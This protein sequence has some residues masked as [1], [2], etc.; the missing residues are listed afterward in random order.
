MGP[1]TFVRLVIFCAGVERP[2]FCLPV[3][4]I[5]GLV[6]A[7]VWGNGRPPAAY[8]Q[9]NLHYHICVCDTGAS[10]HA[11]LGS[12]CGQR[13]ALTL[14]ET[15]AHTMGTRWCGQMSAFHLKSLRC[16]CATATPG[17]VLPTNRRAVALAIPHGPRPQN[18]HPCHGV[19][20]RPGE[21]DRK[22][23]LAL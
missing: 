8:R 5:A 9:N 3:F 22:C 23:T 11:I 6:L 19:D 2:A 12:A 14:G 13:C 20:A 17:G 4:R 15:T 1:P 16:T 21:E 10:I 18:Q 7:C